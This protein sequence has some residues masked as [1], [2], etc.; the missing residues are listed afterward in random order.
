[1]NTPNEM[2]YAL[3][4]T[5]KTLVK[6]T[7]RDDPSYRTVCSALRISEVR[8]RE[9]P[10]VRLTATPPA[11]A[12]GLPVEE[13][14]RIDFEGYVFGLGDGGIEVEESRS[15][16]DLHERPPNQLLSAA[17]TAEGTQAGPFRFFWIHVPLTHTGWVNVRYS[18]FLLRL[19]YSMGANRKHRMLCL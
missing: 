1:M 10:V 18:P 9:G 15:V 11:S 14:Q 2:V 5:H 8:A 3:R 4:A 6:F 12:E 17:T 16:T 13:P 19:I 7:G